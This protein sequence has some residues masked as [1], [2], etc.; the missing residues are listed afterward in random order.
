MHE[1]PSVSNEKDRCVE[2]CSTRGGELKR[3]INRCHVNFPN[4]QSFIDD[5]NVSLIDSLDDSSIDYRICSSI[6]CDTKSVDVPNVSCASLG[7]LYVRNATSK[8]VKKHSF[9]EKIAL[10]T[11]LFVN[12]VILSEVLIVW[13]LYYVFLS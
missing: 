7:S 13:M 8:S 9:T 3:I 2:H 1:S 12:Q 4:S 11:S 5:R 6:D 10:F